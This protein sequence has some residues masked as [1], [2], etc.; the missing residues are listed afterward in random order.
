MHLITSL[1]V[2]RDVMVLLAVGFWGQRNEEGRWRQGASYAAGRCWQEAGAAAQPQLHT[3][4][5]W[6]PCCNREVLVCRYTDTV[7]V[8][9]SRLGSPCRL[10]S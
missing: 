10:L 6:Q 1:L 2:C 4:N 3:F 7:R 8:F 5:A 9:L